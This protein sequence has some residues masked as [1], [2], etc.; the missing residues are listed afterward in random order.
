MLVLIKLY[1][2]GRLTEKLGI[3]EHSSVLQLPCVVENQLCGSYDKGDNFLSKNVFAI[4]SKGLY[5]FENKIV[6]Q[7][8]RDN[9]SK[10]QKVV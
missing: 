7:A 9:L 8:V 2:I 6:E 1:P 5:D 4:N 10:W 3:E